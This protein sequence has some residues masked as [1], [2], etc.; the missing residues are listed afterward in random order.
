[1]Q[2]LIEF[3]SN[4]ELVGQT[5]AKGWSSETRADGWVVFAHD[6]IGNVIVASNSVGV[7]NHIVLVIQR[8]AVA[9]EVLV[10]VIDHSSVGPDEMLVRVTNWVNEQLAPMT[11]L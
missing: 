3:N 2:I 8:I 9:P 7:K 10:G 5:D 1:M 6:D 11:R 4:L